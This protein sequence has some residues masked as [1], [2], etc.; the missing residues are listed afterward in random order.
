MHKRCISFGWPTRSFDWPT[1]LRL[2][3]AMST[4]AH[5]TERFPKMSFLTF[6]SLSHN[7]PTRSYNHSSVNILTAWPGTVAPAP[8]AGRARSPW[9][10]SPCRWM[11]Q[12]PQSSG[13]SSRARR[14]SVLYGTRKSPAATVRNGE[15]SSPKARHRVAVGD[16]PASCGGALQLWSNPE[17]CVLG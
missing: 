10:S 11:L 9:S 1:L 6:L 15:L 12:E 13:T 7:R 3:Q 14:R 17:L 2:A 8:R 5:I 16:L 4:P